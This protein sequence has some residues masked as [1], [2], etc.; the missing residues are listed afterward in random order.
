MAADPIPQAATPEVSAVSGALPD[1]TYYV[2]ISWVN[3]GGKKACSNPA[4]ITT[5]GSSIAVTHGDPPANA[6][7]WHV[8]VGMLR[9]L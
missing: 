8:Y 5:S 2:G 6:V 1:E 4:K 7:G 9:R 3:A